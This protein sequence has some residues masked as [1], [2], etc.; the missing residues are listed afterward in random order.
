MRHYNYLPALEAA[1]FRVTSAPFLDDEYLERFYRGERLSPYLLIRAY[2]RRLRQILTARQYDLIWIEKEAVPWLPAALERP[3][4][5]GRPRVIDFDDPWHLRYSSHGNAIVKAL[6]GHK[7]ETVVAQATVVT[8]GSSSL[9]A[10]ARSSHAKR[11]VEILPTVDMERYPIR[12]LPEEPFTIGWI[13]TPRNTDYLAAIAA[14]L[15]HL[16]LAHGARLRVIGGRR[17][18]SLPGVAIDY[19]PWSEDTEAEELARC[20]VGIMPLVDGPWERSKCGYK[21]IQYM[22]AARP[23]VASPVGANSSMIIP[24]KTGYFASNDEE[25]ISAL[26]ALAG[27]RERVRS[28]GLAARQRA[29]AEYSLQSSGARLIEIFQEAISSAAPIGKIGASTVVG[30]SGER[31]S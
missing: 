11:V 8:V 24:G 22:A 6:L 21:L 25:W 30:S 10:W 16:H 31:R 9:A 17:S 23:A 3:F 12:P 18:F 20:H 13:G 26:S 27:D 7:L 29:E 15:R 28:L 5:G 19:I 2:W 1:G 4:F 14:P